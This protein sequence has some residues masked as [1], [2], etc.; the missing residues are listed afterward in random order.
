M[1]QKMRRSRVLEKL[2]AGEVVSCIKLNLAD[3]RVA[4]IAARASFDCIWMDLEHVG[5][6]LSAIERGI[7]A[8][9][10]HDVDTLVRVSRGSYSDYIRPLEL[11]AAGIMVPH[12]MGL[13]DARRVVRNTRFHP[14]GLRPVDGGNADGAYGAIPFEEYLR[15]A[16]EQRFVVVQ[17]EDPE[18]L[19][20]LDAIA[21]LPGIDMLFFGPGDFSQAIGFPGQFDHPRIIEAREAVARAAAKHG[22]FAGT[23]GSPESLES[24]IDIGYRFVSVG[25]DVIALS[26][27]FNERAAAFTGRAASAS[28]SIYS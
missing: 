4:E 26:D 18:P 3:A 23:V 17:I 11:D 1:T 8:A 2:R 12:L 19:D 5:N 22:K 10:A 13:D 27:Y 28:T 6:D 24:L 16:N 20:E 21:A 15:T 7:W 9:K 14:I 25:A